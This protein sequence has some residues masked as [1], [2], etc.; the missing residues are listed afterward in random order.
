MFGV[1]VGGSMFLGFFFLWASRMLGFFISLIFG[2]MGG[3]RLG[4]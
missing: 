1:C 4:G 3:G 2:G